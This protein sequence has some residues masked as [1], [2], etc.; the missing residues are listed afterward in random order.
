[1]RDESLFIDLLLDEQDLLPQNNDLDPESI[2]DSIPT[3]GFEVKNNLILK[4]TDRS[5]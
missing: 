3:A 4:E 2:P 5:K 1:M